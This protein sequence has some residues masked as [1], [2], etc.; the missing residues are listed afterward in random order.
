MRSQELRAQ[1]PAVTSIMFASRRRSLRPP[2]AHE[3]PIVSAGSCAGMDPAPKWITKVWRNERRT[4]PFSSRPSDYNG[5]PDSIGMTGAVAQLGERCVRNAEV[6][7]STPFRSTGLCD[8]FYEKSLARNCGQGFFFLQ[9]RFG[10]S[11]FATRLPRRRSADPGCFRTIQLYDCSSPRIVPVL[12][13]KRLCSSPTW[14]RS[15]RYMLG[16]G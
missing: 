1:V 2:S 8:F 16:S 15:E 5:R 9:Q 6:E 11:W 10:E 4:I 7:G 12:V 13:A 3:I 14:C